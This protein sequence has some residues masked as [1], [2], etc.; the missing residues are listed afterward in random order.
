ML[1]NGYETRSQ[2]VI[3]MTSFI[4]FE[5]LRILIG[6]RKQRLIEEA[7]QER[8]AKQ[9]RRPADSVEPERHRFATKAEPEWGPWLQG[10]EPLHLSH[11][12][13]GLS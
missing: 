10:G 12:G 4:G 9:A 13:P 6:D 7:N 5:P 11:A 2:E 3:Q 8:L 1:Q